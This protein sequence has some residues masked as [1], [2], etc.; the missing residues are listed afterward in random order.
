MSDIAT[1]FERAAEPGRTGDA[2]RVLRA[3]LHMLDRL[4]P[5][6][7]TARDAE[8]PTLWLKYPP[9]LAGVANS[10]VRLSPR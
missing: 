9:I 7:G 3:V 4:V 8:L 2:P 10:V 6:G 1:G 5:P